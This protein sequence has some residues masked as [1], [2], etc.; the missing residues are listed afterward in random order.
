VAAE[1]EQ[2]Q[3][4][5]YQLRYGSSLSSELYSQLAAL[6]VSKPV[7]QVAEV[8]WDW[9]HNYMPRPGDDCAM[10]GSEGTGSEE[11]EEEEDEEIYSAYFA[12]DEVEAADELASVRRDM[13]R[14]MHAEL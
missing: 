7:R 4:A 3:L 1:A 13:E 11:E 10:D 14:R 8:G 5:A 6:P 2:M 12:E 9:G